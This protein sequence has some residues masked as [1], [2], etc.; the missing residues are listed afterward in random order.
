MNKVQKVI[1]FC[2]LFSVKSWGISW[3]DFSTP[4]DENPESI[5][6]YAN[7]C[8]LGA[9]NLPLDGEGYQVI[10]TSRNR[11][12]GHPNT[13]DFIEKLARKVN[14]ERFGSLLIGDI[15]MP[16][17]GRFTSGHASHQTGLDVDIWLKPGKEDYS[18][19][20]R[21]NL[22]PYRVVNLK[23]FTMNDNNWTEEHARV[24]ATAAMDKS[25][26]RIFVHPV[27]KEALCQLDWNNRDWLSKIRPWW[28][29][30]YHFHVR[31]QCPSDSLEC[32][33][34]ALPADD[35]GCGKELYSWWPKTVVE[36][37]TNKVKKVKAP[38]NKPQKKNRKKKPL[39]CQE[40][41][42]GRF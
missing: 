2:L 35:D 18:I 23:Q 28:G 26:E 1:M 16:R 42:D 17:G 38:V 8:L 33:P 21:E 13:I 30:H 32:K 20:Q 19:K 31:L 37:P 24:I 29:H 9:Q 25:V 3:Q 4:I 11:Y 12:Y 34:Q 7:G 41:L 5:G 22:E 27:I 36:N 39:R 15:S 10:R 6:F 40:I 14:H